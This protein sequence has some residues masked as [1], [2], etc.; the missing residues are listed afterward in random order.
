MAST[1]IIG[2]GTT[3][4]SI[5]EEAQQLHYDLKGEN[6]PGKNVEYIY[7]ETDVSKLPRKTALGKT[8]IEQVDL[9]LKNAEV[10]VNQLRADKNLDSGWVPNA[11]SILKNESGAAGIPSFG[12][13]SIWGHANY[14]KLRSIIHKKYQEISGGN[15]TQILIVGSLTGGTGSGICVDVAYLVREVTKNKNVNGLI[16]LPD[17]NAFNKDKTLLENSFSAL[18][19]IDF[20]DK[21]IYKTNWPDGSKIENQSPPFE[22]VQFLSSEFNN[23]KATLSSL[24]ELIRVAA[25]I[26]AL[27]IFETDKVGNHF[28]D[29]I[30]TR[31]IDSR[32]KGRIM[33]NITAGFFMVQYPKAQLEELLALNLIS[34]NIKKFINPNEYV[35]RLEK[36]NAISTLKSSLK[37]EIDKKLEDFISSAFTVID[38]ASIGGD[39]YFQR[40][41][42]DTQKIISK[43][44]GKNSDERF[45]FDQFGTKQGGNYFEFLKSNS[46]KIKDSLI[47]SINKYI[48]ESTNTYKNLHVS[49]HVIETLGKS[50]QSI[51]TF[52]KNQYKINGND[53]EWDSYL[54]KSIEALLK[55]TQ[56]TQLFG[57]KKEATRYVLE[58]I[59]TLLKIHSLIPVLKQLEEDL[60]SQKNTVKSI[61]GKELPATT[62]I[63][64]LIKQLYDVL[65]GDEKFEGY[66]IKKRKNEIESILDSYTTCFKMLYAF[67]TREKDLDIA[68]SNYMN[69]SQNKLTIEKIFN[70]N[71]VWNYLNGK[72]VDIYTDAVRNTIGFVIDKN[73]VADNNIVDIIDNLK[74]NTIENKDLL[75]RFKEQPSKIKEKLPPMVRL[76]NDKYTFGEDP[77]AKLIILSNDHANLNK[78]LL[79]NYKVNPQ[80]PDENTVDL[81][82]L[83]NAIIFYQEYGY[84]GEGAEKHFYPLEQIAY[85]ENVKNYIRPLANEEFKLLKFPYLNLETVKEYLS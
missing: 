15:E 61:E 83:K 14:L 13:L 37:L 57:I 29:L 27:Q 74:P 67:E 51:Q 22:F 65:D 77:S 84:M 42:S 41:E 12:R 20:H 64:E 59:S 25:S 48:E 26:T 73:F 23:G 6:K 53:T 28:Y 40:L 21:G 34:E 85:M 4:L 81:P 17:E 66:S 9:S 36:K 80:N 79:S 45:L 54:Q 33:H 72:D 16:L 50:I 78:K 60:I 31:R 7:I 43:T 38:A 32:G 52:Y 1:L 47:E 30:K 46:I 3:G 82:A 18:A 75:D 39:T 5:I 24:S 56:N 2:I 69:N 58:Q 63:S 55:S 49:A 10:F 44:H 8:D 71:N 11:I 68:Y 19:A 76:R 70:T 62:K 35:D